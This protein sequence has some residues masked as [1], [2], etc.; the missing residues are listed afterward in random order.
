M[1]LN[2]WNII[3]VKSFKKLN[4][5]MLNS[6]QIIESV[7]SF[8]KLKLSETMHIHDIFHSKL[9]CSVVNDSLSDQKNESLRLIIIN[10][11]DEW[12]IDDILNS[13]CYKR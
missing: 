6:F 3:I 7:D 10:D 12:K 4:D 9:L 13:R 1:F 5:K 11:E 2:E 8:Y